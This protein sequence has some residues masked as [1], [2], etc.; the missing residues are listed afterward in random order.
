MVY[1]HVFTDFPKKN[2]KVKEKVTPRSHG[3]QV[4]SFNSSLANI[5]GIIGCILTR[6][7]PKDLGD[8]EAK[9]NPIMKDLPN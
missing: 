8:L 6:T 5:G 9:L 1:G 3:T 4:K 7:Q 2:H